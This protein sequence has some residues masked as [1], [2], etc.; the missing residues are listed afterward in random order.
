MPATQ[1]VSGPGSTTNRSGCNPENQSRELKLESMPGSQIPNSRP[2]P[3][4]SFSFLQLS[5]FEWRK[6]SNGSN[7]AV[8]S[9]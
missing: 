4:S 8:Y 7:R 6:I 3:V 1:N 5:W 9:C 2:D